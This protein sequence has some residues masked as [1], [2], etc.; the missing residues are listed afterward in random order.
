MDVQTHERTLEVKPFHFEGRTIVQVAEDYVRDWR[1]H[2]HTRNGVPD[3]LEPMSLGEFE[4][5]LR[6]G[7]RVRAFRVPPY[8]RG[9]HEHYIRWDKKRRGERT[10]LC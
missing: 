8:K 4:K 2:T 10:D 1:R 9:R 7:C 3:L 5:M 6:D